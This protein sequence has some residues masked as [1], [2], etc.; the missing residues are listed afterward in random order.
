MCE[1]VPGYG[2]SPL[3]NSFPRSRFCD[4]PNTPLFYAHLEKLIK[5]HFA[6]AKIYFLT[7]ALL[8]L[9]GNFVD[10]G[11]L[12]LDEYGRC[13]ANNLPFFT[14]NVANYANPLDRQRDE[15]DY[16]RFGTAV[17]APPLEELPESCAG[18]HGSNCASVFIAYLHAQLE[19]VY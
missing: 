8:I 10:M 13:A 12:W 15:A 1:F 3:F 18:D 6:E 5:L 19:T 11:E 16:Q 9:G 7:H 14:F 4:D 2:S 17:D